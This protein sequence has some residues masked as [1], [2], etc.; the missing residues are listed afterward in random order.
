MESGGKIGI[1]YATNKR[2]GLYENNEV[3]PNQKN[4]NIET[5]YPARKRIPEGK[6]DEARKRLKSAGRDNINKIE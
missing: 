6:N 1:K 2:R 3:L 5:E 4:N